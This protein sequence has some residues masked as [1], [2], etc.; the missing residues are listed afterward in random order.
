MGFGVRQHARAKSFSKRAPWRK[1][2]V[3][4]TDTRQKPDRELDPA[5]SGAFI[6]RVAREVVVGLREQSGVRQSVGG[7]AVAEKNRYL[8]ISAPRASSGAVR[9]RS[10]GLAGT[11]E[12]TFGGRVSRDLVYT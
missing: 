11:I 5:T 1:A 7:I 3:H 9:H 2:A 12:G 6:A 10:A 8:R 4:R